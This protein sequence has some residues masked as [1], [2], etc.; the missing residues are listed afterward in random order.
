MKEF[1]TVLTSLKKNKEL[2][3]ENSSYYRP[4]PEVTYK[5]S[6]QK[7]ATSQI[8]VE[9]V[10][11]VTGENDLDRGIS[12]RSKLTQLGIFVY[13][14]IAKSETPKISRASSLFSH[15]M[16]VATRISNHSHCFLCE[17]PERA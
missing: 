14:W 8:E 1:S 16:L 5:I 13:I 17:D 10:K 7:H 3:C 9:P 15:N 6:H 12:S 4:F 11:L 2:N